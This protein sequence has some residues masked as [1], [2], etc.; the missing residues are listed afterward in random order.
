MHNKG[1]RVGAAVFVLGL[2]LADR[3]FRPSHAAQAVKGRPAAATAAPVD[4]PTA[5]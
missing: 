4:V 5:T 1:A 3:R 2:S